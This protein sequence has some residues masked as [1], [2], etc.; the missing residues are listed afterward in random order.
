[1][2]SPTLTRG[3]PAKKAPKFEKP[4]VGLTV[5]MQPP[6]SITPSPRFMAPRSNSLPTRKPPW[7]VASTLV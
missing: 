1:M 6:P 4:S 5:T 7:V 3:S 2:L